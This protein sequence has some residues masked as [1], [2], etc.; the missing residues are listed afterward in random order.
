[1]A[2]EA[3][4]RVSVVF[5]SQ[6]REVREV[7]LELSEG[8]TVADAL[9]RSGVL[10]GVNAQVMDRCEVGVWGRHCELSRPLR[11]GDRVE[12]YRPLKVDPQEAR[13]QR[14][15][16]QGS[17]RAGLFAQRREGAKSGY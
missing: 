5:A 3:L 7:V 8:S 2:S 14:F 9:R 15:V 6:S 4:L 16:R 13:R 1:M 17:K 11:F 12:L 10:D